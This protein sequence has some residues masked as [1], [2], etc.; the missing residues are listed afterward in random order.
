MIERAH[1]RKI[2]KVNKTISSLGAVAK[3]TEARLQAL[4][5]F[6]A[7][8]AKSIVALKDQIA[9]LIICNRGLGQLVE[10]VPKRFAGIT[11]IGDYRHCLVSQGRLRDARRYN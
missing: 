8:D 4:T 5:C 10:F 7:F 9:N 6:S 11:I 1:R 2:K 3:E